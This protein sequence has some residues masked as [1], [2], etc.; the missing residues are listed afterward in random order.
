M[1]IPPP[2]I[3]RLPVRIALTISLS[4]GLILFAVVAMPP[5]S[6]ATGDTASASRVG[7][8]RTSPEFVPGEVLV[9]Y[10]SENVAK[11]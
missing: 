5:S 3:D 10:Q 8:K 4:I 6:R 11:S 9:R 2:A 1:P 7:R